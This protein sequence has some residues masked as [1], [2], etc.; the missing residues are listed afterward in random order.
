MT[1][2]ITLLVLAIVAPALAGD[3]VQG[4]MLGELS[5]DGVAIWFR[6]AEPAP[7]RVEIVGPDGGIAAT[8]SVVPEVDADG[9]CTVRIDGLEPDTRY[10]YRIAGATDPGWWFRTRP[11]PDLRANL[12]FGSCARE[13]EA[14]ATVWRRM[15]ADG[16]TGLVLLGD[17]PYIDTTDLEY[18]RKRYREFAVAPGLAE[19]VAHVPVYSTWDD[20]DFGRNDTDGRLEGKE[21]SRQAFLE[22]RPQK[23]EGPEGQGIYTSFR[24]GP[25]EVFILDTRWFARTEG[26][27]EDPTL[28]G[29]A[30]WAWLEKKLAASD[31]PFRIL[32]CGMI[33][34][35]A[36]RPGKTDHWGMYPKEYDRLLSLLERVGSDGVVLV[37]GDIHWS[38]EIEHDTR[39]RLGRNLTEFITSP[40]HDGLI[41]AAD[42]PH[43]GIRFTRG[44]PHV[45]LQ[46]QAETDP[47][48]GRSEL[49]ARFRDASG[50]THHTKAIT[51]ETTR[52]DATTP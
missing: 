3:R 16:I 1:R 29:A 42:A 46:L 19:L 7:V 2:L 50:T 5:T 35:G 17:T 21:N 15:D 28:L 9:C 41:K 38:R 31:A 14:S 8:R 37:G 34:N 11:V 48:T 20:H 30:Q 25:I 12:A 47:A 33:F 32:A 45:Y 18:Q 40:I 22:H 13:D 27:S 43:P 4:P 52:D 51:V 36:T 26:T 39:D 49:V 6:P 44:I 23:S 10:T 24:Q